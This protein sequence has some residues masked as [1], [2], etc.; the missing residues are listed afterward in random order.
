[1]AYT[2]CTEKPYSQ[3]INNIFFEKEPGA[4]GSIQEEVNIKEMS[5]VN[6]D[7]DDFLLP[8]IHFLLFLSNENCK[9]FPVY[10]HQSKTTQVS[11]PA[12]RY[13]NMSEFQSVR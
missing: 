2:R 3:V 6:C 4:K 1:M 10:D 11:L 13:A 5:N 8:F 12:M 7:K 9:N